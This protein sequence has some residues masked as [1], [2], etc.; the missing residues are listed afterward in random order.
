MN[1]HLRLN[2]IY[3]RSTIIWTRF[4]QRTF[5]TRMAHCKENDGCSGS[6]DLTSPFS[7]PNPLNSSYT[8]RHLTRFSCDGF[9]IGTRVSRVPYRNATTARARWHNQSEALWCHNVGGI[10][11]VAMG[12]NWMH[13]ITLFVYMLDITGKDFRSRATN[14]V[15]RVGAKSVFIRR[16]MTVTLLQLER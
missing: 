11:L 14:H 12:M 6:L 5:S 10:R 9:A 15:S 2:K 3:V 4:Y 16:V 7:F 13:E 1:K 8:N